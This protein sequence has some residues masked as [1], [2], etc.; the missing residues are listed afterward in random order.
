MN[1][2]RHAPRSRDESAPPTTRPCELSVLVPTNSRPASL[3][4]ALE[5]WGSNGRDGCQV[6]VLNSTPSHAGE[7]VH[8]AYRRVFSDH[9]YV[10][11]L[12]FDESVSPGRARRILAEQ[13]TTSHLLF[14][15]DDHEIQP[16]ALAALEEAMA[17]ASLDIVAGRWIDRT[18]DRALCF[19]HAEGWVDGSRV[20]IKA[21]IRPVKSLA[22]SVIMA[23]EVLATMLCS[24]S[25]F[26]RVNFDDRY[27]FYF[28]LVDFFRSC[29]LASV[30]V[31]VAYDAVF[32]HQPRAYQ[33]QSKRATQR[34]SVD[35]ERFRDKWG[36]VPV[37]ALAQDRRSSR[38]ARAVQRIKR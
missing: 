36:L 4:K 10:K 33:G 14:M 11:V 18:Q 35:E 8:S 37:L 1:D 38:I 7:A 12:S 20:L 6:V 15:D 5:A 3:R 22:G 23:D 28:E 2:A 17:T 16:G 27:D 30:R 26:D 34:R 21:P 13:C 31:G 25:V 24:R 29:K 19:N 9:P 32:V